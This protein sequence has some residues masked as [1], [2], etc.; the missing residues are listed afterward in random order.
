MSPMLTNQAS[1]QC[2]KNCK[3]ACTD[4]P[5]RAARLLVAATT[6]GEIAPTTTVTT[7]TATA[8]PRF[9]GPG[10]VYLKVASHPFSPIQGCDG[11]FLLSVAFEFDKCEAAHS[12]RLPICGDLDALDLA[13]FGEDLAEVSFGNIVGKVTNVNTHR[14]IS[15][16]DWRGIGSEKVWA[17][18]K[19]NKS[20]TEIKSDPIVSPLVRP[21]EV[22]KAILR[23]HQRESCS[24]LNSPIC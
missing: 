8:A 20:L 21:D 16:Q 18:T 17:T 1:R 13:V 7:A 22:C 10:F 2:R 12:P 15:D 6:A 4:S 3:P 11:S 19:L 5:D 24:W 14:L 23:S 9:A